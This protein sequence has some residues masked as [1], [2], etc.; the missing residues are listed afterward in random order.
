[1]PSTAEDRTPRRRK[2]KPMKKSPKLKLN[3]NGKPLT[4]YTMKTEED[5]SQENEVNS[6]SEMLIRQWPDSTF[7]APAYQVA[8]V[9]GHKQEITSKS[10]VIETGKKDPYRVC[11][12][13][14]PINKAMLD[15]GYPIPNIN[16]LFPLFKDAKY[17]AV[18]N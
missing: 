15:S 14:K 2:I 1:M 13:Y 18:Y 4:V 16:F 11:V 10:P 12:N 3:A 5:M 7:E 9:E 8:D 6:S 17:F